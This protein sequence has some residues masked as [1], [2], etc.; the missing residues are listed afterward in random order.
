MSE[1]S[2]YAEARMALA[3]LKI[4]HARLDI[5][6]FGISGIT[7]E[8]ISKGLDRSYDTIAEQINLM[9]AEINETL[10]ERRLREK[11]ATANEIAA[12]LLPDLHGQI[13]LLAPGF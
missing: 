7:G 13:Q 8:E 11:A 12:I 1:R 6:R 2:G 9:E 10:D 4:L 3:K 5:V